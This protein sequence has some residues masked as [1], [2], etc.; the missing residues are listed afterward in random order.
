MILKALRGLS[1]DIQHLNKDKL[2]VH[3]VN[4]KGY[5]T[6]GSFVLLLKFRNLDIERKFHVID[7][8][9]CSELSLIGLGCMSV[10][11]SYNNAL[12][13]EVLKEWCRF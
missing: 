10:Y 7:V 12:V 13:Y 9:I 5:N 4:E 3:S 2:M 8:D 11:G 6:L 1:L